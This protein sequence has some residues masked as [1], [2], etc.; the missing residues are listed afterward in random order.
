MTPQE[1]SRNRPK[2][3]RGGFGISLGYELQYVLGSGT[4]RKEFVCELKPMK[5]K[6][7]YIAFLIFVGVFQTSLGQ[8][9]KAA[10]NLAA[11]KEVSAMSG[12]PIFAIAGR[13][14]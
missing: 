8:E 6:S 13:S 12:R 11:A 10:A 1:D 5:T 2:V 14:T 4:C 7:I 3:R 9:S